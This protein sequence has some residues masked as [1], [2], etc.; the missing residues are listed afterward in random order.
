MKQRIQFRVRIAGRLITS[1]PHS[2]A[3][4]CPFRGTAIRLRDVAGNWQAKGG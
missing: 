2:G 4:S 1:S 3:L